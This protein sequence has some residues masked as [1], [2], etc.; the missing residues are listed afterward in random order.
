MGRS[1]YVVMGKLEEE[2]KKIVRRTKLQEAILLTIASGGRSGATALVP[3]VLNSLLKLDIP[4]S[5]RKSEIIRSTASRL[6]RKGL[7]KFE[8]GHYTLAKD[9]EEILER[10]RRADFKLKKPKRWDNKWRIVIFDI[11]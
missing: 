6:A 9:G 1:Y 4:S 10:W 7:V 5:V 3:E 11:H 8:A 2:N